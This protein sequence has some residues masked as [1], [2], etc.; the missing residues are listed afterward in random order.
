MTRKLW[1]LVAGIPVIL[2]IIAGI[3]KFDD[4]YAHAAQVAMVERRLDQK[5]LRDDL[6]Y[7]RQ[8]LYEIR[9]DYQDDNGN[10]LPDVPD[11]IKEL[12]DQFYNEEQDLQEQMGQ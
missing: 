9:R 4:R 3:W 1:A 5:I 8:N 10:W 7:V 11:K 2:A 6:R 12:Y